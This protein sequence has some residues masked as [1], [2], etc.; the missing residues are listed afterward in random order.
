MAPAFAMFAENPESMAITGAARYRERKNMPGLMP[1][2]VP[3]PKK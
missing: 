3:R 2:V 1:N